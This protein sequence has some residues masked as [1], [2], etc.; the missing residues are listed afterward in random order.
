MSRLRIIIIDDA[1]KARETLRLM[2]SENMTD[3][4]IVG[5]AGTLPDGVKLIHKTNPD[6]VLLD[7]EMPGH[8]GLEILDFF[9][10]ERIHFKIIFVTAYAEHAVHAFELSAVDYILKPVS[11]NRLK[12]ALDKVTLGQ[13][14]AEQYQVLKEQTA[15]TWNKIALKTGDGIV[16]IP[17]DQIIYLKAEGAYTKFILMKQETILVSKNLAEYEK[18]QSAGPFVRA[19]RSIILNL[20]RIKKIGKASDGSVTMDNGDTL[21]IGDETYKQLVEAIKTIKLG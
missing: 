2:I 12:Q 1:V 15:G 11:P 8:S 17:T 19:G 13:I 4:E 10:P 14:N 16:F 9:S 21:A 3:I 20:S 18:L 5:E 6:V 7:I